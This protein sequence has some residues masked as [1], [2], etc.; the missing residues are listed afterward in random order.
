MAIAGALRFYVPMVGM[1][2]GQQ[3]AP[4]FT[5]VALTIFSVILGIVAVPLGAITSKFRPAPVLWLSFGFTIIGIS[6]LNESQFTLVVAISVILLWLAVASWFNTF[7]PFV[8][9]VTSPPH[10]G[11][12]LGLFFGGFSATMALFDLWLMPTLG[13]PTFEIC[14]SGLIVVF[15]IAA[16]VILK[17]SQGLGATS[18]PSPVS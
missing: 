11:F 2:W 10:G 4:T 5:K 1:G 7:V 8:L 9:S 13:D 17:L 14:L 15:A 6:L 3:V 12:A 16:I 18:K